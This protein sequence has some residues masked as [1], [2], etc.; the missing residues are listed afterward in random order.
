[1]SEAK[2]AKL[3][4]EI[5]EIT[6]RPTYASTPAWKQEV[7][8]LRLQIEALRTGRE[9]ERRE[10]QPAVLATA[11]AAGHAAPAGG[12]IGEDD[13]DGHA[14]DHADP[15]YALIWFA[16]AVLTLF[17]WKAATWLGLHGE[18]LWVGLSVMA[19]VK[20]L[21]VAFWFMHLAFERRTFHILL[22]MPIILVLALLLLNYPDSLQHGW[23]YLLHQMP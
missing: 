13:G 12:V 21:M 17:E 16:L 10:Y 23:D 8:E 2:I 9:I 5:A 7:A 22:T 14:H 4:K 19:V 20:A 18:T 11:G 6:S 3:E 15:H 1:M